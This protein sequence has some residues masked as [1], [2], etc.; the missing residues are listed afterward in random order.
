MAVVCMF[1]EI[2]LLFDPF[3]EHSKRHPH[4]LEVVE[5]GREIKVFFYVEAHISS[6][7]SAYDTIPQ[8]LG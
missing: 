2:V 3:G 1:L 5:G 6:V 4:V 8:E 7:L